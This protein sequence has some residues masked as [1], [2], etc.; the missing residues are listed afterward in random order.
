MMVDTADADDFEEWRTRVSSYL[1]AQLPE[2]EAMI[3]VDAKEERINGLIKRIFVFRYKD[4]ANTLR[5]R[6]D[7]AKSGLVTLEVRASTLRAVIARLEQALAKGETAA[8]AKDD[9]VNILLEG[10]KNLGK[11]S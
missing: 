4:S 10:E 3:E 9:L 2:A 11:E 5:L 1:R 8:E 6:L 7:L